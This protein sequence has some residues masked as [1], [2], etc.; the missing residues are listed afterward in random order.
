[1]AQQRGVRAGRQRGRRSGGGVGHLTRGGDG[2][3]WGA[4]KTSGSGGEST[5]MINGGAALCFSREERKKMNRKGGF[6]IFQ[7]LRGLTVK[8]NFSLI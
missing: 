8:Q 1:M 6:E 4:G 5:A 2:P 3:A 7:N